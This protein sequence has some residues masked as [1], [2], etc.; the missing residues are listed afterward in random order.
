MCT[1]QTYVQSNFLP[2]LFMLNNGIKDVFVILYIVNLK[3]DTL[4]N[5]VQMTKTS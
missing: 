2:K 1:W 4:R 5:E 3:Y